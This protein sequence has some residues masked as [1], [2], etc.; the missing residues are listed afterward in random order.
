MRAAYHLGSE[1]GLG[2]SQLRLWQSVAVKAVT[3][4]HRSL[5]PA[6]GGVIRGSSQAEDVQ[7]IVETSAL[8][9][10]SLGAR[11]WYEWIDCSSNGSDGLSREGLAC[12]VARAVCSS[13]TTV[14]PIRWRG[15]HHACDFLRDILG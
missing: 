6:T 9:C 12:P 10:V 2:L 15:R 13:L 11:V 3:T 8:L 5:L 7:A 1:S 14:E 4:A